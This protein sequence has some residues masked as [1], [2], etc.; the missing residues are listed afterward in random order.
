[1]SGNLD[2]ETINRARWDER[3]PVHAA[4]QNYSVDEYTSNPDHISDVVKFDI[5]LLGDISELHCVHLQ[6]HIGTDTLSLGRLGAASVTGLDFSTASVNEARRLATLTRGSGGEKL[7]FVEASVVFVLDPKHQR[8]GKSRL[9]L[10]E[11]GGRLFIREAHPIL[12]ALD[13]KQQDK[14]VLEL[15][16]FERPEPVITDDDSTYVETGGH[17]F[18]A[19]KRAKFNHGLGEIVQALLSERLRI[20]GLAEHQSVPWLAIP[21]QMKTD[22]QGEK[23]QLAR[24]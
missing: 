10:A 16:Y 18:T 9:G 15:P 22:A 6:C 4:S 12:W 3:A 8:L 24:K 17:K 7:K 13:E 23:S 2:Y 21:G 11:A 20:S 1:M 19:T 14:L 5:P